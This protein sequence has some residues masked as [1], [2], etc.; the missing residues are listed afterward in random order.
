L[1]QLVDYVDIFFMSGHAEDIPEKVKALESLASLLFWEL[2]RL[3]PT[4]HFE[5]S[6]GVAENWQSMPESER[7]FYVTALGRALLNRELVLQA[8]GEEVVQ[9]RPRNCTFKPPSR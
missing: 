2:E 6:R 1:T 5:M 3:D 9:R 7:A 8:L 4:G